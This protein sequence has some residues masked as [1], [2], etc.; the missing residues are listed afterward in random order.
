MVLFKQGRPERR[1]APWREPVSRTR[2]GLFKSER[3]LGECECGEKLRHRGV[4]Y[5]SASMKPKPIRL[6]LLL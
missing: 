3:R 1:P 2:D 6:V 5:Q 4:A